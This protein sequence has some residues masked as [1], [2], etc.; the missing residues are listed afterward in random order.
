MA[1]LADLV[2]QLIGCNPH[3]VRVHELHHG[4][5]PAVEGDAA[6]EPAEGVLAYGSPQHPVWIAVLQATRGAVR[7]AV[8]AMDILTEHHD[9]RVLRH[10]PVHDPGDSFDERHLGHLACEIVA[11]SHGGAVELMEVTA[12]ANVDEGGIWPFL[13]PDT[14]LARLPSWHRLDQDAA[15]L[16][17]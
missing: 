9:P 16:R 6:A 12:Y 10:A 3:E 1:S 15:D 11:V 17:Q 7:T 14:A 8:Q 13:G 2:E 4:P 5:E